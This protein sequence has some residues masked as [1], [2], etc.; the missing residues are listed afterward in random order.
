MHAAEFRVATATNF[1]AVTAAVAF[2]HLRGYATF[3]FSYKVLDL[4]N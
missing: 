4:L 3:P 2:V 1:V